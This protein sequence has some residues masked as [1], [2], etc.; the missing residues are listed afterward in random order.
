MLSLATTYFTT[1]AT[2]DNLWYLAFTLIAI[3]V[4]AL[5]VLLGMA[6]TTWFERKI[7]GWMHLRH[8][9]MYTG[10]FGLLQ[11]IADAVKLMFKEPFIPGASNKVMFL[12]A[13]MLAFIP[14]LVAWA[15][16]PFGPN[17]LYFLGIGPEHLV[18]ANI[19][20]GVLFILA[21]TSIEVYGV[22]LAGWASNSK[23]PFLGAVRSGAQMIS[24]EVSMG[25]IVLSVILLSGSMNL[26]KIVEAQ[27]NVWFFIPAFPAFIMFMVSILA[28]TNRH[29]FDLPEAEAE[30]VAGYNTEYSAMSFALFFLGE[31]VA[32]ITM[33]A[34]TAILF[35]GGWLP[36]FNIP[37]LNWVP[38]IVW[39]LLKIILVLFFMVWARGTLPRYRYDQLMRLGWKIFLPLS[40]AWLI[41][42]AFAVKLLGNFA[43]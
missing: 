3:L 12:I 18:L 32:M 30:L 35:L 5:P 27:Q 36:P 9:P 16:V 33:S 25:L 41:L 29:P 38:G 24:Y 15:V 8:G 42:T 22:L 43:V 21:I 28:E 11:P 19:N 20:L 40:F 10:P 7:L 26:T 4:I 37:P 13:P 34:F 31:Y 23:Y 17:P 14:V 2:P 6:Y 1:L 39:L